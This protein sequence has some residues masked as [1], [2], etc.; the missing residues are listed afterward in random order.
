MMNTLFQ[1]EGSDSEA[2]ELPDGVSESEE[3]SLLSSNLAIFLTSS[4]NPVTLCT[5]YVNLHTS[6]SMVTY[7]TIN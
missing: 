4:L 5:D 6:Y 1:S 2:R 7:P 3:H